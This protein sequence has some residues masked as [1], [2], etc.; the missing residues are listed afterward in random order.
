MTTIPTRW[1]CEGA[2]S[3]ARRRRDRQFGFKQQQSYSARVVFS[4]GLNE[5]RSLNESPREVRWKSRDP[6]DALTA[7]QVK[8]GQLLDGGFAPPAS[9]AM[10]APSF[11]TVPVA[12]EPSYKSSL[13]SF[14]S[15]L[16]SALDR[17]QH[18][19]EALNLPDPG[20]AEDLGREVKSESYIPTAHLVPSPSPPRLQGSRTTVRQL[21]TFCCSR[22]SLNSDPLDQLHV[23]WSASRLVESVVAGARFPGH[24]LVR[25][26]LPRAD[27]SLAWNLLVRRRLCYRSGALLTSVA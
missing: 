14:L 19:R 27:G 21:T 10:A 2:D 24:P 8:R 16:G 20:K 7:D 5:S 11:S 1:T 22:S 17:L 18:A 4:F 3:E 6:F 15:P 25:C 23:R 26:W 13:P 9:F 12:L